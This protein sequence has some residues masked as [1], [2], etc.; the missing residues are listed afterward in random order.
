MELQVARID[1][2]STLLLVNK[3]FYHSLEKNEGYL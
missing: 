3:N 2:N 1:K